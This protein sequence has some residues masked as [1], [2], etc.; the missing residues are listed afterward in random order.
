MNKRL[1][2]IFA[3]VTSLLLLCKSAWAEDEISSD[4]VPPT[5]I[6]G[7]S[8]GGYSS[9]SLVIPRNQSV[10]AAIDEISLILR[11]END[12]RFKFFGELELER[13]I[14]WND[15]ERI[16]H[17]NAYLDLER[18]YL[19]YNL[20]EKLNL[21]AGRFLTPAGRWN[22]LHA[23]PLV[24]TTTR[25]LVTS[26]LFPASTNGLMLY[27]SVPMQ[28]KAFEYTFFVETLKDQYKDDFEIQYRDVSG[29]H[30]SLNNEV[31]L[32]LTLMTLRQT[33][34][35]SPAYRM[36][37]LDF[38]TQLGRLELSGES[39]YRFASNG[40]DGGSGA[41]VQSAYHLGNEWYGLARLETFQSPQE[42]SAERWLVGATKRLKPNQLL[43]MEFTGG[44]GELPDAPRGFI[45]SFAILF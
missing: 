36:I 28:N 33:D 37:G 7:F 35:R 26:R 3:S 8:L 27:G 31:N 22:L 44:S 45:G 14:S 39:Y 11:W 25:P 12:G 16:S 15:N 42:G 41:Y 40:K 34:P 1:I 38:L 19:D 5:F 10:E 9:A 18:L 21:R 32:G 23:A 4:A 6:D 2:M 29:A 43:K 13:P 20:S 17:K 30:F 24:W